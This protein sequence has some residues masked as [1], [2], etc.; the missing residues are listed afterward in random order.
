MGE[1]GVNVPVIFEIFEFLGRFYAEGL[2]GR[3][4]AADFSEAWVRILS[5]PQNFLHGNFVLPIK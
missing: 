2:V 4:Y 1:V 3:I 5:L